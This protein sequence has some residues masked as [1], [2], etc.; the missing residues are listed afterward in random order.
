[1]IALDTNVLLRYLLQDDPDQAARA[2]HLL[3]NLRP[4]APGWISTIVMVELTWALERSY[5][6]TRSEISLALQALLQ[7][8]ELL[9]EHAQRQWQALRA[10]RDGKTSYANCLIAQTALAAGCEATYSFDA[11]AIAHAGM[12][13][14][15][16]L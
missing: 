7:S 13:P 16:L 14:V 12:Q 2:T 4:E 11:D 5:G 10:Y 15:P 6:K 8:R 9:A 3:D 1:M